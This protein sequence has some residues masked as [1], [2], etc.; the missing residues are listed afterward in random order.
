MCCFRVTS[1][2]RGRVVG[3]AARAPAAAVSGAH[4]ET[5]GAA[6]KPRELRLSGAL[7]S[8]FLSRKTSPE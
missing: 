5:Q 4:R 6:H 2:G 3:R 8:S 7:C 1:A